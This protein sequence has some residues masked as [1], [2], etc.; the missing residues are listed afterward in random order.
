MRISKDVCSGVYTISI[1]NSKVSPSLRIVDAVIN[2][3]AA[4]QHYVAASIGRT[5]TF[6]IDMDTADELKDIVDGNNV[7]D[8]VSYLIEQNV[9]SLQHLQFHLMC[10]KDKR[11]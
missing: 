9:F 11:C 10:E 7:V 8:I 5:N 6:V 4:K 1:Q 2:G 3:H